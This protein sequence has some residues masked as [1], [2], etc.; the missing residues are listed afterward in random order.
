L[1][2]Q[3][4]LIRYRPQTWHRTRWW[5]RNGDFHTWRTESSRYINVLRLVSRFTCPF[6]RL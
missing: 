6:L 5:A 4:I 3:S 2:D 1:G